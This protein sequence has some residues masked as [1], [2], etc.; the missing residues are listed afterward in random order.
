MRIKRWRLN[1]LVIY[2]DQKRAN[3]YRFNILQL[4]KNL[5]SIYRLDYAISEAHQFLNLNE[6]TN[7]DNIADLVYFRS[8]EYSRLEVKELRLVISNIFRRVPS[9]FEE[10]V[11]ICTQLNKV[12]PAYPFPKDFYRPLVFPYIEYHKGSEKKLYI[13]ANEVMNIIEEEQAFPLN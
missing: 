10:G 3:N 12:L 6:Q 7:D 1:I 2:Y 8:N 11:E 9:P 5:S 13:Y 4:L